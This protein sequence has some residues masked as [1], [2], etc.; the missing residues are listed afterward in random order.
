MSEPRRWRGW[1]VTV[2]RLGNAALLSA[3]MFAA[4]RSYWVQ[5]FVRTPDFGPVPA[6]WVKSGGGELLVQV[7][8]SR[9][10]HHR[11]VLWKVIDNDGRAYLSDD[12]L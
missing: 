4:V 3:V 10:T 1:V 11:G 7:F 8:L 9:E 2:L 12:V 6:A 5:D